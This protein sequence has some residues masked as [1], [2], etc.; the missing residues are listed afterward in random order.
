MQSLV[1]FFYI[2]AAGFLCELY[3]IHKYKQ[4]TEQEIVRLGLIGVMRG[5]INR[6]VD[7]VIPNKVQRAGSKLMPFV[8]A[9]GEIEE[10]AKKL[11]VN[12]SAIVFIEGYD[13]MSPAF[14]NV[15]KLEANKALFPMSKEDIS[16]GLE[17]LMND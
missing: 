4:Y 16:K 12:K 9:M 5:V 1:I 11:S 8:E 10:T 15:V 13:E 6:H 7:I 14:K 3:R 2:V 17:E